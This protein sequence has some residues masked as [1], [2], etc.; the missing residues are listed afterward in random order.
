MF[1]CFSPGQIKAQ[2]I[3]F[4]V[5]PVKKA[6]FSPVS[7][8]LNSE[9]AAVI[10]QESG[11]TILDANP[12]WGF[13][14]EYHYF[15]RLLVLNKNG[16]NLAKD[17]V[18]YNTENEGRKLKSL[19]VSTYNL[20]KDII[21]K[22]EL[23][24]KE[25]FTEE[26]KNKV[27][28][29]KFAYPN[30]KAGTILEIE[31][32]VNSGPENLRDWYFQGSIPVLRSSYAV[33]IPSNWNFI[34][35]LQNNKYLTLKTRDSL[36]K[37]I[38]SWSY[39]YLNTKVYTFFWVFENVPAMIE[40]P[41]TST[42]DN[43]IG[44]VKFQLALRPTKPG[45]SERMINDWQWV[46]NRL[47]TASD[48]GMTVEDPKP[49][50]FKLANTIVQPNEPDLEKAHKL[51]SF[52]R[53]H[54]K[55]KSK[56]CLIYDNSYLED[57]YKSGRGNAAET[58][59]LLASLLKT[60]KLNV[61][62]VIL[63]TR[64]AGV[65]NED[66]P[67]L[68]NFNYAICRLEIAGKVYFL[69][70]TDPTLGFDKLPL[71][72]YNGQARVIDKKPYAVYFRPDS[73][74]ESSG[75]FVVIENDSS[76][77][78]LTAD[79]TEH[80]GYYECSDIR[81]NILDNNNSQDN[82]LKSYSKNKSFPEKIDSFQISG[83]QDLEHPLNLHFSLRI[84]ATG[85]HYYFNPMMN[86]G[87]NKNPFINADRNYPVELP[88]VFDDVYVLNMEIPEGYEVEEL[89]KSVRIKLNE[90][91]G[92][93]EYLI[94]KN[95]NSIQLKNVLNIKKATFA[96]EDYNNLRDFYAYVVKKQAEEIVFKKIKK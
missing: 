4:V 94:Q 88:Y 80:P 51:F 30:V 82:Y 76:K 84:S 24:E 78:F 28:K 77:R 35:S 26:L 34:I 12:K 39:Q 91:D 65:T 93:F 1:A 86:A 61:K 37:D 47:L 5:D 87:L 57:V 73:I 9:T 22:T 68:D 70:A 75:I 95:E 42:I 52:V 14:T 13:F 48:F 59:L 69:D 62:G 54:I 56:S 23:P 32:T 10:L 66:Y 17:S 83:L 50:M 53:D 64:G 81:Q 3:P 72:C 92:I 33:L 55:T 7:P 67:V 85:E 2:T 45:Q 40:E 11:E 16:L 41:Y 71:Y 8:I 90:S 38:Y 19:H 15:K 6:D 49:W 31:Y 63:A 60:Q 79:W 18:Y 74:R 29:L 25:M 27:R 46:S 96:P 89:P 20:E 44:C 43:Y 36:A 21:V 58:N